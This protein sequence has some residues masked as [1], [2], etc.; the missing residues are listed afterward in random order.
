MQEVP[1]VI[2][3]CGKLGT[4]MYMPQ[5]WVACDKCVPRGC[6]CQ[7]DKTE[8][9]VEWWYDEDGFEIEES[10][11]DVLVKSYEKYKDDNE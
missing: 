9:C 1:K 8:P 7:E 4:W 10:A 11:K 5:S 6:S 3:E 2:C